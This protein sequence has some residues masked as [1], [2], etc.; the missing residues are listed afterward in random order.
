MR[1]NLRLTLSAAF[2]F[3]ALSSA[4]WA[5]PAYDTAP[6]PP[7]TGNNEPLQSLHPAPPTEAVAEEDR[8]VDAETQAMQS[9]WEHL[10][11]KEK[12]VALEAARTRIKDPTA[13]KSNGASRETASF[14]AALKRIRQLPAAKRDAARVELRT[15]LSHIA[16]PPPPPVPR[17]KGS[18]H[19]VSPDI[20]DTRCRTRRAIAGCR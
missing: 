9:T 15:A 6:P 2:L 8:G 14:Q 10:S 1:L 5:E 3:C 20:L 4:A 7:A 19:S 12:A 16:P 13:N 11:V 17:A 18:V